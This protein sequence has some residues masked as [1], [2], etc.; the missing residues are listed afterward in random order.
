MATSIYIADGRYHELICSHYGKGRIILPSVCCKALAEPVSYHP[1]M[2]LF[3]AGRGMVICA[4]EVFEAYKTL[5]SPFGVRLV[6]G[7]TPLQSCYPQDVAY[8]VLC[9][10]TEAFALWEHTDPCIVQR[11]D[12]Q[13]IRRIRVRQGYARCSSLAF[14][15]HLISSD[16]SLLRAAEEGGYTALTIA[17]GH[18]R[19]PG[20]S[21]G[22]IGGASGV[23][24][25]GQIGFAGDLSDHPDGEEIRRFIGRQGFSVQEILGYPLTDVGTILRIDL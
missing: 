20:Y 17:P 21:Y 6:Q 16:P 23:F 14:G 19:L 2:V 12:E 18:I 13:N 9:M 3:P 7:K 24:E 8:N 10:E 11:L 5:L 22:F 15:R 4:P 1:D 25:Q